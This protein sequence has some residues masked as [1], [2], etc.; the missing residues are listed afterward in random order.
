MSDLYATLRHLINFDVINA[1]A[2]RLTLDAVHVGSG[3]LVH[4]DSFKHAIGPEHVMA[5][6]ALPPGFP[7]VRIDGELYWDGGVYS[8]TPLEA[9][10][11]DAPRVDTLC[12]MVDLWS[13]SGLEPHSIGEA[14]TRLREITYAS[15]SD[16]HIEDYRRMHN[17]R[18]AVQALH[19]R[20]P[21]EPRNSPEMQALASL[22]CHTTMNIVHL[23]YP[24]QNWELAWKDV[25]FSRAAT[26]AR[27]G[28]GYADA[29]CALEHSAWLQLVPPHVGVVVHNVQAARLGQSSSREGAKT[30]A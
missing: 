14:Q 29:T 23:V 11:D 16:R 10:L 22:G 21:K 15:R 6:G 12:F 30:C 3:A 19:N 9:V 7:A 5:S 1:G 13:A 2:V 28:Q 18:R 26:R 25:N 4:F 17:L 24:R 20:L 27:W 8:N